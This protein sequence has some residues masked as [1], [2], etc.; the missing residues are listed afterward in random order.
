M[1]SLAFLLKEEIPD[2][3]KEM[4]EIKMLPDNTNNFIQ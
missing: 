4:R 1:L 2:A 3:F